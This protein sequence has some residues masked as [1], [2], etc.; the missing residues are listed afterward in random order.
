MT[1]TMFITV[2][3]LALLLLLSVGLLGAHPP[4]L[5][6]MAALLDVG[7]YLCAPASS[8]FAVFLTTAIAGPLAEITAIHFGAWEYTYPVLAGIPLWLPLVW[9]GAGLFISSLTMHLSTR[10]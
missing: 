4:I 10:S 9:G 1:R 8:R 3:V 5:L 6:S 7:L 2:S